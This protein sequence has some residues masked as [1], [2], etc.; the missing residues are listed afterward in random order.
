M[1]NQKRKNFVRAYSL[2]KVPRFP[3]IN[4]QVYLR[5]NGKIEEIVINNPR[6]GIVYNTTTL[7]NRLFERLEKREEIKEL[8][9]HFQ[10]RLDEFVKNSEQS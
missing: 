8:S 1:D 5:I 2:W 7:I 3:G 10:K 6:I 9:D 4:E